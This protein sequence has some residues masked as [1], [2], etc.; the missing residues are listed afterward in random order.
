MKAGFLSWHFGG[1]FLEC[2]VAV[3]GAK[4]LVFDYSTSS[5]PKVIQRPDSLSERVG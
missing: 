4:H 2:H 3:A 1:W 5:L